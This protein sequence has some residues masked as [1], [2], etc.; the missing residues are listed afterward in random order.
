VKFFLK[1]LLPIFL[2]NILYKTL[3]E[4]NFIENT[5][6]FYKFVENDY[7]RKN[8]LPIKIFRKNSRKKFFLVNIFYKF[9]RKISC[10]MKIFS[11][12]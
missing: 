10:N 6:K 9:A 12:N 8:Y 4:T 11:S 1:K 7:P 2:Q 3:F 5:Y